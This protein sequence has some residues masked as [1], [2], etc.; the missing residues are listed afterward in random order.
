MDCNARFGVLKK[1]ETI[2][3]ASSYLEQSLQV[4]SCLAA[5]KRV[6]MRTQMK[7][8]LRVAAK[9]AIGESECFSQ[10]NQCKLGRAIGFD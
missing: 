9:A 7:K 8:R 4:M 5:R 10:M 3:V 2:P 6:S 1:P